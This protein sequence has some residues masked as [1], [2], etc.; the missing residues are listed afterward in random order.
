VAYRRCP[1]LEELAEPVPSAV[2][3]NGSEPE[4]T[5][6]VSRLLD[7]AGPTD[8]NC[9][10]QLSSLAMPAVAAAV[11]AVYEGSHVATAS[12]PTTAGRP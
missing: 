9:P 8:R 5:A 10:E 2:R 6:V 7:A 4:L 3:L 1:A 12:L 11:D